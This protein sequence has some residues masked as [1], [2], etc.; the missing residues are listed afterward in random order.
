[1]KMKRAKVLMVAVLILVLA[2][3]SREQTYSGETAPGTI[4]GRQPAGL[5]G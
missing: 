1:M 3:F 2:G 4:A 5:A